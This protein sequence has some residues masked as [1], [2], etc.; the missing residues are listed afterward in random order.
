MASGFFVT[1][2]GPHHLSNYIVQAICE[3]H[4]CGKYLQKKIIRGALTNGREWIF[5]LI[6][7]NDNYDGASHQ[8]SNIVKF[9]IVSDSDGQLEIP[10]SWHDTI[11]AILSQWIQNSFADLTSDDLFEVMPR[12]G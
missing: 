11:A 8:R 4:A 12:R 5:I 2:A 10:G 6:K 1:V 9:D 7:F 3:M